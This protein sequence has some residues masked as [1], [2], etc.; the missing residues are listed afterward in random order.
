MIKLSSSKRPSRTSPTFI[1]D[2]VGV[3]SDENDADDE[4]VE[5]DGQHDDD[6]GNDPP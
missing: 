6:P 5:D 4:Q 2:C 3:L 1:D